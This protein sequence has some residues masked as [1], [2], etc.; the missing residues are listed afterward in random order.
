MTRKYRGLSSCKECKR[1]INLQIST[2]ELCK[3]PAAS[4]R[5]ADEITPHVSHTFLPVLIRNVTKC[6]EF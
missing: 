4:S 3:T 6:E 2:S 5:L 1:F